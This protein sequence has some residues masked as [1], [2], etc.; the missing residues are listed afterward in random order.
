MSIRVAIGLV[1]VKRFDHKGLHQLQNL[2]YWNQTYS[3]V[4]AHQH[5]INLLDNLA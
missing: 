4:N 3:N 1:P 5:S 2:I